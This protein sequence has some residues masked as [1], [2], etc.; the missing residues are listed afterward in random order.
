MIDHQTIEI[1]SLKD[2]VE[3]L[4]S[5]ERRWAEQSQRDMQIYQAEIENLKKSNQKLRAEIEKNYS[6]IYKLQDQEHAT[7]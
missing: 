5:E 3:Q 1:E 6:Q 4:V 2:Q 7:R